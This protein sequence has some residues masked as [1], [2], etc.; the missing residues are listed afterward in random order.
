MK[1]VV[2]GGLAALLACGEAQPPRACGTVA[3]Q[4]TVVGQT[5]TVRP[6]FEDP[7]GGEL[8]LAAVSSQETVAST[9]ASAGIV[10]VRGVSPGTAVVTVTATDEDNMTGNLEFR[11][12]VPNRP[13]AVLDTIPDAVIAPGAVREWDLAS[14]FEEPDGQELTYSASSSD[15]SVVAVTVTGSMLEATGMAEGAAV[16]TVTATDA[17]GL[18]AT[19]EFG[20]EVTTRLLG[21]TWEGTAWRDGEE[22]MSF[23]FTLA[24]TDGRISGTVEAYHFGF[25]ANGSGRVMGRLNGQEVVLDFRLVG[26]NGMDSEFAYN[27]EWDEADQI[28]GELRKAGFTEDWPLPLEREDE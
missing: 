16:V 1:R 15:E 13:P 28:D 14:Y 25:D 7:E 6:C 11:V 26:D 10:T 22:L 18:S 21:G 12:T 19:Q 5:V 3:D 20:V 17:M 8:T 9:V 23:T 27:G 2:L 4:E 24:V